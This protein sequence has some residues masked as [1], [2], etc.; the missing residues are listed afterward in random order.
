VHAG[1]HAECADEQ[2]PHQAA[3]SS[4]PREMEQKRRGS[5][6]LI[7][8]AKDGLGKQRGLGE[9]AAWEGADCKAV[10]ADESSSMTST[11]TALASHKGSLRGMRSTKEASSAGS[12]LQSWPPTSQDH[13]RLSPL[14]LRVCDA[15]LRG[16]RVKSSGARWRPCRVCRRARPTPR[17]G[18]E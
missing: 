12:A 9:A 6:K 17:G 15:W 13:S 3:E 2:G 10:P 5:H 1:D 18:L 8:H 7:R 4:G 16:V 11:Q 14:S